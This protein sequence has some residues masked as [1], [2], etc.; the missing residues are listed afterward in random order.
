[1]ESS[2]SNRLPRRRPR[3]IAGLAAAVVVIAGGAFAFA[4]AS[5]MHGMH[6]GM[7]PA[8]LTEHFEVH[9]KHVLAD[10]DATPEQQAQIQ[11]IV[12]SAVTDLAALHERSG[13]AHAQLLAIL[14]GPTIDRQRLETLRA[15]HMQ[16]FD[17]ASRRCA[18]AL[19]DAADV[20]TVEQRAKLA[21]QMEKHR[22]RWMH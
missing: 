17:A 14:S 8:E 1:M 12:K 6:A 22:E 19:A 9:V 18:T 4:H 15:E 3:F 13:A 11:V 5:G 2:Q 16:A 20:L 21:Q 7:D 10:V